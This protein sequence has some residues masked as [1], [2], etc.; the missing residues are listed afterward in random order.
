MADFNNDGGKGAVQPVI[1]SVDGA[2]LLQIF[3]MNY[4]QKNHCTMIGSPSEGGQQQFDNRVIQP[5]TVN[6]TGIIKYDQRQIFT[7]IRMLM[8]S[9]NLEK[10]KCQFQTKAG[11][12]ENMIIES[13][14][15]IG[16]S[17]RYDGIEIRVSLLEYLEHN[18]TAG[19]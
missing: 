9:I 10:L 5:S 8:K 17:N 2:E 3:P 4:N 12:I 6:F 7:K 18:A 1:L 13:L 19:E 11:K 16:E 15:E 14:E